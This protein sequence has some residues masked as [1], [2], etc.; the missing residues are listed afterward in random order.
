MSN[1]V[2]FMKDILLKKYRLEEF[3]TFDLTEGCIAMLMNK[4]PPKLKDLGS[5]NIPYSIENYYVG[6]ALCDL[7]ASINLMPMSIL[8]KLGLGNARPTTVTL[9]LVDQ[10]YAHPKEFEANQNVSIILG[11]P[12]LATSR[13]L[14]D[15][16]KGELT[17]RVND[18]Q[19]TFNVFDALKYADKNEECHLICLIEVVVVEEFTKLCHNNFDSNEDSLERIDEVSLEELGEFMEA[20]QIVERSR[21]KFNSLDLSNH[22]FKPSTKKPSTLE[23]KPLLQHLKYE[24]LRDNNILSFVIPLELTSEQEVKLL[25]VL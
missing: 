25:E 9:Q 4:L 16:Q 13:T 2:K 14:I 21:K 11:R 20:K 17:I 12:F 19:V 7:G 8:K 6:K 10:S 3:E 24:Y 22:S 5:F 18:Q 1:Y 15:V 23:L